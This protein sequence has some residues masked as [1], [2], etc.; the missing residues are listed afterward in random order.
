MQGGVAVYTDIT[1]AEL[2]ALLAGYDLGAPRALKGIAEGIENSNFVLDAEA[3]RFILTIYERRVRAGDLPFFLELMRHLAGRGFPCPTPV[4]DRAGAAPVAGAGQALRGGG[5][6]ARPLDAGARRGA[7]PGGGGGAGGAARGG[8]G[9]RPHA[10]QR[11]GSCR[12]APAAGGARRG[13]RA[14]APG[15]GRQRRRRPRRAGA[16]LARATCRGAWST[17]TSSPTT[18]SSRVSASPAPSTSTSPAP[19]P[20]PTIWR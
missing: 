12:L 1:D 14:A 10:R 6:P 9:L 7:V 4:P 13:G 3:G 19:T 18:C 11:P 16:Q 20:W 17:P 5:L 8:R 15:A 2:E